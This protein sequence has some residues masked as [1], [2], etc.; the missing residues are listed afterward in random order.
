MQRD[1]A[2]AQMNISCSPA[3][4]L[5][6]GA[7][8]PQCRHQY[9]TGG[10]T[11]AVVSRGALKTVTVQRFRAMN[12]RLPFCGTDISYKAQQVIGC[13][14]SINFCHNEKFRGIQ[15]LTQDF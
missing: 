14:D 5:A 3:A 4:K 11:S 1:E 9:R 13:L 6:V 15:F 8:P 7:A 2:E 10:C 12:Q